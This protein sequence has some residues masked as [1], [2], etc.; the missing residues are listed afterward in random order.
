MDKD[1]DRELMSFMVRKSALKLRS[2]AYYKT[3]AFIVFLK[4]YDDKHHNGAAAA[5]DH[6][7]TVQMPTTDY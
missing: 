1:Y 6:M 3:S 7:E 4:Q 2:N 5:P